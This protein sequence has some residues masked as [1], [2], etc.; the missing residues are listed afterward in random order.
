M[1]TN[2]GVKKCLKCRNPISIEQGSDAPVESL[3]PVSPLSHRLRLCL[4][5]LKSDPGRI[6]QLLH[7]LLQANDNL[8]ARVKELESLKGRVETIKSRVDD[9]SGRPSCKHVEAQ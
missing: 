5:C 1:K 7:D 9:I 3:V 4:S 6:D 8:K 2:D